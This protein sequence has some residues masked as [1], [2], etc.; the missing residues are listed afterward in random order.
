MANISQ[1]LDT[2]VNRLMD[3]VYVVCVN[4]KIDYESYLDIFEQI[5]NDALIPLYRACHTKPYV[6]RQFLEPVKLSE[7]NPGED[8]KALI[9]RLSQAV[10]DAMTAL[11]FHRMNLNQLKAQ[12]AIFK[13]KLF[14]NMLKSLGA[15][16]SVLLAFA[17]V[18]LELE[19]CQDE[20]EMD[21]ILKNYLGAE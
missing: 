9:S 10:R 3:A 20:F 5:E 7:E 4:K 15:V 6:K 19:Q 2:F 17:D 18:L 8:L 11:E 16:I 14:D 12:S 21:E 13:T 1:N